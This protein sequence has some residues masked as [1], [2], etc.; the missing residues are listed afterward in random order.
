L[1]AILESS[2]TS[3]SISWGETAAGVLP[4][5]A[6]CLAITLEGGM[7][8]SVFAWLWVCGVFLLLFA[9]PVVG[10]IKAVE[11][12]FPRWSAPY[13]GLAVLD[14]WLFYAI[15]SQR[16]F[17]EPWVDWVV[18]V[19]ILVLIVY[20]G[21]GLVSALRRKPAWGEAGGGQEIGMLLFCAYTF[22]PLTMLLAF[23]EIP[24]AAKSL[25][26]LAGAVVLVLG[27]VV[28]MRA[29]NRWMGI[30]GLA[31]SALVVWGYASAAAWLFW[32]Y[33]GWG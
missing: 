21:V 12:G 4:V 19:G 17:P 11:R 7:T 31:T 30:M 33:V 9:V 16:L 10:I 6:L 25:M 24:V 15:F 3:K 20:F 1:D 18:R 28:Y 13:L 5:A 22:M 23:D 26:I 8:G 27:G 29:H 14:A 2:S 32:R